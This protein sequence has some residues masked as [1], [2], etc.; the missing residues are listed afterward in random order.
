MK[1]TDSCGGVCSSVARSVRGRMGRQGQK[2]RARGKSQFRVMS[3]GEIG[4]T[5]GYP[6]SPDNPAEFQ[7]A[8]IRRATKEFWRT[9]GM[10][11]L[12]ASRSTVFAT[13]E[14]SHG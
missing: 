13:R 3:V 4:E 2:R 1:T 12:S 7:T 14:V 10:L 6:V 8:T 11:E 5:C 9:R